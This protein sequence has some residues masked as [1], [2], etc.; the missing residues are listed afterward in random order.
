MDKNSAVAKL[1]RSFLFALAPA[2]VAAASVNWFGGDA[3]LG[4]VKLTLAVIAAAV[5]GVIAFLMALTPAN[6]TT[7]WAKAAAHFL[8]MAVAGLSTVGIA[9][10]SGAAAVVFAQQIGSIALSAALGALSVF[11]VNYA[12]D[13]PPGPPPP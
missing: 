8:Q 7:S 10:L 2:L 11:A 4:A 5:T 9:D 6:P 1:V 13:A 3:K 12:E